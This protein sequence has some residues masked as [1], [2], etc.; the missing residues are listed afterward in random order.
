M[1]RPQ[2]TG[3]DYFPFEVDLFEDEKVQL[4]SSEFG[5]K[6]EIVFVRLL[7]KI[8]KN[9]Y[10]YQWGEDEALL[11]AKSVGNDITRALVDE[12]VQG[13]LRRSLFDKRVFEVFKILTSK[14]IQERYEYICHQ[15]KRP[16]RIDDRTD[17]RAVAQIKQALRYEKQEFPPVETHGLP[18]EMHQKKGKEIKG[19]EI[20]THTDFLELFFSDAEQLNRD[21]LCQLA[22]L[23]PDGIKRHWVGYFNLHLDFP[24]EKKKVHATYAEWLSHLRHWLPKNLD[25]LNKQVTP[26]GSKRPEFF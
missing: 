7:C 18:E 2:K 8:Y 12:V 23:P 20:S 26:A 15:L 22:R 21:K 13:C 11:F 24:A 19:K 17:C 16:V 4:I 10:Q 25:S 6:G 14:G 5:I 1:A 9:G 3:L